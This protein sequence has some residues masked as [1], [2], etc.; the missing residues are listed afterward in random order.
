MGD[1][2]KSQYALLKTWRTNLW[3]DMDVEQT[4]QSRMYGKS[5]EQAKQTWRS[6]ISVY[7]S[8]NLLHKKTLKTHESLLEFYTES[9]EM[10]DIKLKDKRGAL[11]TEYLNIQLK[12]IN[13]D[14]KTNDF[15]VNLITA[16]RLHSESTTDVHRQEELTLSRF[17]YY[18]SDLQIQFNV[19][20]NVKAIPYK[21]RREQS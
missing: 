5:F 19:Y 13:N 15:E 8:C 2:S 17:P 10:Q 11:C 9:V 21:Y 18:Q 12:G 4:E 7:K 16:K 1:P 6:K 3:F 14:Y 20:Q